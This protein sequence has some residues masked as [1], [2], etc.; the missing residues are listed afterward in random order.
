M[1]S[2][3]RLR[4]SSSSLSSSFMSGSHKQACVI[5][6]QAV[7]CETPAE[8]PSS[9]PATS[10]LLY[11]GLAN[12][13]WLM[14]SARLNVACPGNRGDLVHFGVLF[15][16][17]LCFRSAGLGDCVCVDRAAA[18]MLLSFILPGIEVGQRKLWVGVFS[19]KV[20][21]CS[22]PKLAS[23]S[24]GGLERRRFAFVCHVGLE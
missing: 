24:N 16:C 21:Q 8:A 23:L 19:F 20:C 14:S 1:A 7:H 2:E 11:V 9:I 18:V 22:L 6:P 15:S 12:G 5:T 13:I 17:R 3:S 10:G 4:A